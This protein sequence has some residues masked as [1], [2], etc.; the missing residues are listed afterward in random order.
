MISLHSIFNIAIPDDILKIIIAIQNH[1][2]GVYR[3]SCIFLIY[4]DGD[5][6]WDFLPPHYTETKWWDRSD[7][8]PLKFEY[9]SWLNT[10][11]LQHTNKPF[12]VPDPKRLYISNA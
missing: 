7:F 2:D 11:K 12:E 10:Y 6:Y 3:T 8:R 1:F 9:A 4:K 5:L